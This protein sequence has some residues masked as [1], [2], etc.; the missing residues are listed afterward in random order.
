MTEMMTEM[1]ME[2]LQRYER[3]VDVTITYITPGQV[4]LF[5]I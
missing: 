4:E 5:H 3:H 2:I 1:N